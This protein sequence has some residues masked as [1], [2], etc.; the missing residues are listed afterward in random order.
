MNRSKKI[1]AASMAFMFGISGLVLAAHIPGNLLEND[2]FE[3][4]GAGGAADAD[5]WTQNSGANR[6]DTNPNTGDWSMFMTM[7]DGGEGSVYHGSAWQAEDV[8]G[9]SPYGLATFESS[10]MHDNLAEGAVSS[11][12]VSFDNMSP[13]A[14]VDNVGAVDGY[15]LLAVSG[16]IPPF[17]MS[18]TIMIEGMGED[19]PAND[20]WDDVEF[21]TDCVTSYSKVSGKAR[22][23]NRGNDGQNGQYSFSGAVGTLE[24]SGDCGDLVGELHINYKTAGFSCDF[25]PTAAIV[26]SDPTASLAVSYICDLPDP[27]DDL[28]G[29]AVIVLTQGAG[30]S[31]GKGNTKDRGMISVTNDDGADV[32]GVNIDGDGESVMLK[33]GNVNLSAGVCAV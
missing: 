27:D 5:M 7:Y 32:D 8:E 3:V 10:G 26:Y 22:M 16:N 33:N 28:T 24:S 19:F 13:F 15:A 11:L 31:N 20:H 4:E 21:A 23:G 25:T 17:A 29:T 18:A 9:C 2:G 30:G 1:L 12:S 14:D 6:D